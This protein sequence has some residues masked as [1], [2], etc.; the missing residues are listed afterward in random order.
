[1]THTDRT[2]YGDISLPTGH[3]S[4]W[5]RFIFSARIARPGFGIFIKLFTGLFVAT[6]IALHGIKIPPVQLD[7]RLGLSVGAIFAAVASEYLVASGLPES[8]ELT[9]ADRLH[10]LSFL[11]IFV[12]LAESVFVYKLALR[13][14]ED[15]AVRIDGLCFWGFLFAYCAVATMI[16]LG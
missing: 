15:L 4:S 8:N 10:I 11:L 9:L 1:V 6:A 13:Q 16:V 2:N 7:A 14:K 12:T 3:E 5:S